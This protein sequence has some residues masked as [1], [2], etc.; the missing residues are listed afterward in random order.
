MQLTMPPPPPAR[1]FSNSVWY[2]I[3]KAKERHNKAQETHDLSDLCWPSTAFGIIHRSCFPKLNKVTNCVAMWN[4]FIWEFF[5]KPL[6]HHICVS[7][8][9]SEYVFDEPYTF[10]SC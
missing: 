5:S 10:F 9:L 1:T 8:T 3:K 7:T 4:R 2:V 6:S